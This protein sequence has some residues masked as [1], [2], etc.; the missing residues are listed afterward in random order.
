MGANALKILKR[1]A[2]GRVSYSGEQRE[3]ILDEFERSGLKGAAFARM[4]GLQYQ[5]KRH[6]KCLWRVRRLGCGR[7]RVWRGPG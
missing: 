5:S 3:A 2:V 4:T 7:A 1:D 6:A